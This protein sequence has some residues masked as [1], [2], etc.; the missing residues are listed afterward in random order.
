MATAE[1]VYSMYREPNP[2]P[3]AFLRTPVVLELL[4]DQ[5]F[6]PY[7]EVGDALRER[8]CYLL[9][10]AAAAVDPRRL[11]AIGSDEAE[12]TS[13]MDLSEVEEVNAALQ[14][15]VALCNSEATLG[16]SVRVPAALLDHLWVRAR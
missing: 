12:F 10:H 4:V 6:H 14:T 16:F 8:C 5:L 13:K 3:V 2:P 15:S 1:L 11:S 7:K 9:A